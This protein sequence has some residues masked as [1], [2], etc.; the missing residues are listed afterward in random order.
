MR[1]LVLQ[2][3]DAEH[4]GIFRDFMAGDGVRWDAVHLDRGDTIPSLD[5]YDAM[6][7][8][9]GPMD[10]WQE[11]EHPWLEAEKAAIAEAVL[12]RELPYLG[13]CLGHQLLAA[14]LGGE[15]AAMPSPEVG[16]LDVELT[17]AGRRDPVI[18]SAPERF[19]A[20]QWHGAEVRRPP[21]GAEVLARSPVCA[22]QALRVGAAAFGIQYHVELTE[23][24]VREWGVIPEYAAALEETLG[25]GGL[26]RM[27]A[28]AAAHM[29]EFNRNA[30]R[31]HDALMAVVRERSS[32]SAGRRGPPR[33]GMPPLRPPAAPAR[34]GPGS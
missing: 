14:A 9:G 5:G 6:V 28:S 16:I 2:H 8:M 23:A 17:G 32:S 7:V 25:P 11:D 31:L 24:T 26:E 19:K 10:V 34:P 33:G 18:G 30:R 27:Q 29:R 21:A 20:L 22:I 12:D 13:I 4:P 15:V 1:F 3:I